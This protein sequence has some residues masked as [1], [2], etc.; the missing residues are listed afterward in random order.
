MAR[1]VRAY[2][3][4]IPIILLV[5]LLLGFG[6][7]NRHATRDAEYWVDHTESVIDHLQDLLQ[8]VADVETGARGYILSQSEDALVPYDIA[9]HAI[10]EN[11]EV[12]SRLVADNPQQVEHTQQ[13]AKVIQS[14]VD[15]MTQV[16]SLVK[17]GH[18]DEVLN[19]Q[20]TGVGRKLMTDIRNR[21]GEMIGV[22]QTLLNERRAVEEDARQKVQL[23][24]YVLAG[25]AFLVALL[26]LILA[27]RDQK[28]REKA[29]VELMRLTEEAQAANRAKS[30]FLAT[31]SHEIRTPMNGIIGLNSLLL[32]TPLTPQQE[33]LAK[34]VATSADTLLSVV[35]DI[36]D[37]SKL[38]AGRVEIETID[39]SPSAVI[40]AALDSFAVSAQQKGLEIA[41]VIDPA[42]PRWVRGDPSRFRQVVLNLVGNALKFTSVGY[43]EITLDAKPDGDGGMLHVCVTDT[44]VGIPEKARQLLFGKFVQADTSISRRYGGTGLGLAISKQ[45]VTL[46]GGTIE[47]E[48][49]VGEGTT[50]RF[51]VR[52]AAARSEPAA[53][54]LARPDLLKG[55]RVIVVDDTAINRR[56]IA[57]QLESCG[58]LATTVAE[59]AELVPAIK[60]AIAEGKPYDVAIL[61]QN[62]PDVSGIALARTIR[63]TRAFADLKLILATSVGLPN[64]SDDARHVGFD[65]FLAKPLKHGP[66]VESLCRVLGL[67]GQDVSAAAGAK[68]AAQGPALDVLVAE[69]NAINQQL[70]TA[71]LKKWGHRITIVDSGMAAVSAAAGGDFDIVLMDLQMP[72]MSGIEAAQRI[73]KIAGKRGRVPMIALTAHVL[74]SIR[75]EVLAAGMQE[76]VT[77]PIDPDALAAA[78]A[79]LVPR[80]AETAPPAPAAPNAETPSSALNDAV[81]TRLEDQIGRDDVAELAA[82]LL[83]ETPDR[84]A[85]IRRT[86]AAGD[87]AAARQMAH[88]IASTAGNLGITEV[89]DLAHALEQKYNAGAYGDLESIAAQMDGAY[90]AA[91]IEL[92]ARYGL[93]A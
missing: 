72:G 11:I 77:K 52:Y 15:V 65:D 14:K 32:D 33:G 4:L 48:S 13:L 64:P 21:I 19:G 10:P 66:L 39:Y 59:P 30:D 89:A 78:I 91:A 34:G 51:T 29:A 58:I 60:A 53:M 31:M 20:H 50:F 18:R 41:G 2:A 49:V 54:A 57:G 45:L 86:L 88:D 63:A 83:Q 17:A 71:L 75:D 6:L 37:I 92:K 67:E 84:L 55:R 27:S 43:I 40:E 26:L 73:R 28:E 85:E 7:Y 36:L 8:E 42:V 25:A 47:V 93:A 5:A 81:L 82:M 61:D 35:N 16:V 3:G 12:L 69:D 9:R 24:I 74:S 76:H 90:Y 87:A 68:P 38:E 44:G 1:L 80:S 46:M 62:M 23:I 56:A 22:E 70:I 79:R